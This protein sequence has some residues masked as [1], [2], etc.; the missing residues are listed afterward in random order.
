MARLACVNRLRSEKNR[1]ESKL[2]RKSGR[3]QRER[4][5]ENEGKLGHD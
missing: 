5:D 4:D 2:T 3:R 1:R